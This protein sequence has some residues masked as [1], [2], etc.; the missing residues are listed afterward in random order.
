MDCSPS[1]SFV[2]GILQAGIL[3]SPGDLPDPGMKPQ[4]PAL[5]VDSLKSEPPGK[6]AL[7]SI[8][9]VLQLGSKM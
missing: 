7:L 4:S 8:E 6:Q 3:D 9:L 5:Q 1:G 2:F